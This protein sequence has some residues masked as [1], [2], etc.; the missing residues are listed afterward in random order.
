[1]IARVRRPMAITLAERRKPS[2]DRWPQK[3]FKNNG[4]LALFRLHDSQSECHWAIGPR[5]ISPMLMRGH[6][7]VGPIRPHWILVVEAV[8]LLDWMY[9]FDRGSGSHGS[10][11]TG[12][13]G[14]KCNKPNRKPNPDSSFYL[15][16]D[17]KC[18]VGWISRVP[19]HIGLNS[20]WT[21]CST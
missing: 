9:L 6:G 4:W 5:P 8:S 2:G 18:S 10:D 12:P 17:L 13:I 1:M 15:I 21:P 20:A 19:K 16:V 7:C 3:S 11:Y 14:P